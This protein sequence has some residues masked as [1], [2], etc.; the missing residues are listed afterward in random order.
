MK[1]EIAIFKALSCNWRLKLL[2]ELSKEIR[3]SCE[4]DHLFPVD[5]T[6]LSRHIK[7]LVDAGLVRETKTGT[8]KE[9]SICDER[10]LEVIR[11]VREISSDAKEGKQDV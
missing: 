5:K 2:D 8:R 9:L 11:L 4:L 7:L 6:T 10:I 1:R 3:C